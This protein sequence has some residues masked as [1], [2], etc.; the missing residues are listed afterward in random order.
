MT[1]TSESNLDSVNMN[2][3]GKYIGQRAYISKVIVRTRGQTHT[4][5]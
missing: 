3:H 4:P 1:L 2:P 5:D